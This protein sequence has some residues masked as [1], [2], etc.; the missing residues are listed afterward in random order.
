[1]MKEK[2]DRRRVRT[3]LE[4]ENGVFQVNSAYTSPDLRTNAEADVV[5]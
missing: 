4:T 2:G 1:M 5:N 3:N